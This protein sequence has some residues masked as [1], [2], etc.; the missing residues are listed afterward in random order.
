MIARLRGL[1]VLAWLSLYLSCPALDITGQWHVTGYAFPTEA[2][3]SSASVESFST[4]ATLTQTHSG[5]SLRFT[6]DSHSTDLTVQDDLLFF[7]DAVEHEDYTQYIR[8]AFKV[9][10]EDTIVFTDAWVRP[11]AT[12]FAGAVMTR[13]PLPAVVPADWTGTYYWTDGLRF[14]MDWRQPGV[15]FST[16]ANQAYTIAAQGGNNYTLDT[17]SEN[18]PFTVSGGR[19]SF[20]E[21]DTI[22]NVVFSNSGVELTNRRKADRV[23]MLQ[24]GGGRILLV[25]GGSQVVSVKWLLDQED[26]EDGPVVYWG[27][28]T[29]SILTKQGL[30]DEIPASE[31]EALVAFYHATGGPDWADK[32]GWLD[33][34]A[35]PWYGVT[36]SGVEFDGNGKITKKGYVS[37]LRLFSN[38]LSG[39]IP[40]SLGN[41]S[42]LRELSLHSNRLS[43][44]IPA[45]LGSLSNLEELLLD[46]NQLSGSIPSSLGNLDNLWL[47]DLY[48]NLL[49]GEIPSSLGNLSNLKVLILSD[50]LLEGSIPSSLGN[51]GNLEELLLDGNQLSGSIPSSLGNLDNLW[52]LSLDDNRLSG[53]I[54][55]AFIA[56]LRSPG[57]ISLNFFTLDEALREAL[58]GIPSERWSP[59]KPLSI[60]IESF[61]FGFEKDEEDGS[62][63]WERNHLAP[64]GTASLQIINRE[65]KVAPAIVTVRSNAEWLKVQWFDGDAPPPS[66]TA[67][68]ELDKPGTDGDRAVFLFSVDVSSPGLGHG[69]HH[70][71]VTIFHGGGETSVPVVYTYGQVVSFRVSDKATGLPIPGAEI[72][73]LGP[74]ALHIDP[75]DVVGA[76]VTDEEGRLAFL[77]WQQGNYRYHVTAEG[78]EEGEFAG[79]LG[80]AS[81]TW[82]HPSL[83][84]IGDDD[85]PD[86]PLERFLAFT[87]GAGLIGDDAG[88]TATPHHDGVPN[89]LKY[90]FNLNPA[91]PDTRRLEAGTGIAGLP[92]VTLEEAQGGEETPPVLRI[93]YLRRRNSG[94]I[95]IAEFSATLSANGEGSWSP[96][97]ATPAVVPID[98]EWERVVV[99]DEIPVTGPVPR[100]FARVRVELPEP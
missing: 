42:N 34:K 31:Y 74:D 32:T 57:S 79:F 5:Y 70:A 81:G 17:G 35:S 80:T 36:V 47:L 61:G 78:Y 33:P 41:L 64:F 97:T 11:L 73:L 37:S 88:P 14:R 26:E 21:S 22:S 23:Y 49:T 67:S 6:G 38:Q 68:A 15:G 7:A 75:E 2:S 95:Y 50:N 71:T 1:I 55:P 28:V 39:S 77:V 96:A 69:R 18:L 29:A 24:L 13:N 100:R 76:P 89:L 52:D 46:G 94:L 12:D 72:K 56:L 3:N 91:G 62:V 8:S 48:G 92:A 93:E 54:P 27:D 98:A 20:I 59:Q 85:P 86:D 90:S 66:N 10:D 63:R 84:R 83:K 43:G 44:S 87:A 99:R 4:T 16:P 19:L 9:V 58:A 30:Q 25:N 45:F 65:E 51:L 60:E 82:T 53:E 40:A